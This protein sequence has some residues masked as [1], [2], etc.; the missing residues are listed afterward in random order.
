MTMMTMYTPLLS[1]PDAPLRAAEL[2]LDAYKSA[3]YPVIDEGEEHLAVAEMARLAPIIRAMIPEEHRG[4]MLESY[5]PRGRMPL[6]QPL[7]Y[8]EWTVIYRGSPARIAWY[9]NSTTNLADWLAYLVAYDGDNQQGFE[10]LTINA[11]ARTAV[12]WAGADYARH[13]WD[14]SWGRYEAEVRA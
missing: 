8:P 1:I 13:A 3:R 7:D 2:L 6:G 11:D 12:L 5:A 4:R 14:R 9:Q 10:A